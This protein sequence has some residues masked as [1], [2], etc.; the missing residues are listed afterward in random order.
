VTANV[1]MSNLMFPIGA[2]A[3][4]VVGTLLVMLRHHKPKSDEA[5]M[6]S[7]HRGLSALAPGGRSDGDGESGAP[8]GPAPAVRVAI[9]PPNSSSDADEVEASAG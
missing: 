1:V 2:V 9:R 5:N 3:L 6:A 8:I 4:A 7:F